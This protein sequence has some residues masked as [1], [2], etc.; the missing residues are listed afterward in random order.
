MTTKEISLIKHLQD[1]I[2]LAERPFL[3]IAR[4]IGE[5]EE[6]VLQTLQDWQEKNIL[7]RVG[8]L[9]YHRKAGFVANG[10]SVWAVPGEKVESVA[11]TML[12]FKQVGHCYER[13][14]FPDWPYNLYA[15]IH[16]QTRD[17]VK[18]IAAQLSAQIHITDYDILFT[19]REF[20][21]A[22]MTFFVNEDPPNWK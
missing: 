8:A 20:K 15:M 9:L 14:P 11:A 22:S 5:T 12:S 13:P 4:K 3:E 1:D 6:W 21:K 16:G 19:E 10:M 7:R 18:A 2:Y 17:Q